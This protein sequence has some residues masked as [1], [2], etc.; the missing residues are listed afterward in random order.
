MPALDHLCIIAAAMAKTGYTKE[1]AQM[2]KTCKTM[3]TYP[4]LWGIIKDLRG[5]VGQ[6]RLMYCAQKG[7]VERMEWL[8]RHG[9]N[10]DIQDFAGYTALHLAISHWQQEAAIAL[11][12]AGVNLNLKTAASGI[13]AQDC[14]YNRRMYGETPLML[15]CMRSTELVSFLCQMGAQVRLTNFQGQPA[16]HYALVAENIESAIILQKY[17]AKIPKLRTP[18]YY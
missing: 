5:P 13:R 15:A 14:I 3:W 4:P 9:S 18:S 12:V 17:G 1:A 10:A 16:M 6:T 2:A 7:D 8:L 11:I